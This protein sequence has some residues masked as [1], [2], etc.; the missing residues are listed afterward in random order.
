MNSEI[1]VEPIGFASSNG[2]TQIK[3]KIWSLPAYLANDGALPK[4]AGI[5]Q[6]VHGMCEYIDRYDDFARFLATNGFVVCGHDQIGHGD[7]VASPAEF[8]DINAPEGKDNMLADV[9]T[10]RKLVS[11]RFDKDTPYILFGHSMGSF[12]ARCYIGKYGEGL[13]GAIIC[14]TGNVPAAAS[15]FGK[16][17]ANHLV[18]SKG[19]GYKSSFLEGLSTGAYGKAIKDARTDKDWLSYN[20]KNVD[21]YIAD[22]R[23]GFSFTAGGYVALMSLTGEC[24]SSECV[25]GQPKDMPVFVI[26]GA[27]DPVGSNGKGPLAAAKAM[28]DAGVADVEVKIYEHMR[29]E[30]L[31]ETDHR[32]V[33]DDILA[34]IKSHVL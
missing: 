23:C 30:I 28:K 9:D 10:L 18:K 8:G 12:V 3:G 21:K 32:V 20:E 11:E 24:V 31:N 25:Q 19:Q 5:V 6:L 26:S 4:P 29:H 7:S 2:Y 22:E 33:Y 1:I 14:G 13:S 16:M 17:I 15:S 27:E 34:W